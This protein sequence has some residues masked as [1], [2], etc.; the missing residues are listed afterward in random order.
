M[1]LPTSIDLNQDI[2][3]SYKNGILKVKLL[4]K[5]EALLQEPPKKVIEVN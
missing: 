1:M 5:E 4:K 2:K 3:A